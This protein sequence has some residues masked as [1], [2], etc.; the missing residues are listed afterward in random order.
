MRNQK[1]RR[2]PSILEGEPLSPYIRPARN[3]SYGRLMKMRFGMRIATSSWTSGLAI[4]KKMVSGCGGS[5]RNALLES[6]SILTASLQSLLGISRY[7]FDDCDDIS[8]EQAPI[9][10]SSRYGP[11]PFSRASQRV[12]GRSVGAAGEIKTS[13]L[14]GLFTR[15]LI[16]Q[17]FISICRGLDQNLFSGFTR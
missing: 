12:H 10:S 9:L 1:R 2:S 17:N 14:F 13:L 5:F 6:G 4:T 3:G 11:P 16:G 7:R 8:K 15:G